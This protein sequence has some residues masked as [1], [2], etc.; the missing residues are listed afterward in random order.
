VVTVVLDLLLIPPFGAVGAAIA[1]TCAY[2]V[3]GLSSAAYLGRTEGI[4]MR[5]LFVTSREETGL[6]LH[7]LVRRL[8]G[9]RQ[10][11]VE[12]EA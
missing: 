10:P 3:L 9:R 4:A 12:P 7:S 11:V 6:L 2:T 8:P 5:S 1:S